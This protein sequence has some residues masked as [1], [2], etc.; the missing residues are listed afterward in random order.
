M[1]EAEEL[2]RAIAIPED[3]EPIAR[4]PYEGPKVFDQFHPIPR[5]EREEFAA[6]M[7]RA[8]KVGLGALIKKETPID[9]NDLQV[10]KGDLTAKVD[11]P[12]RVVRVFIGSAAEDAE[13]ERN[14][15]LLDV[16]PFLK[17]FCQRLGYEFQPVDLKFGRRDLTSLDDDHLMHNLAV[18][19][20]RKCL[21]VSAGPAFM[22]LLGNK[23]GPHTI[24]SAIEKTEFNRIFQRLGTS[25]AAD[26]WTDLQLLQEWFVLDQ[27]VR[28]QS[29]VLQPISTVLPGF[30]S[31]ESKATRLAV[32]KWWEVYG[33]IRRLLVEGSA[34]LNVEDRQKY[35]KG[36]IEEEI[37][38]A[39]ETDS[40]ESQRALVFTRDFEGLLE[41]APEHPEAAREYI[42]M[43]GRK[44]DVL[45]TERLAHLRERLA[46]A[47]ASTISWIDGA[48]FNPI[49]E[50]KHA[51]HIRAFCDE[52]CRAVANNA[53]LHH[54]AR[55]VEERSHLVQEVA[56]HNDI[57]AKKM[58]GFMGHE[59]LLEHLKHIV[60]GSVGDV[61]H[62]YII[63]GVSGSGKSSL[64]ASSIRLAQEQNPAVNTV[65]RA[66][67]STADSTDIRPLLR[68]LI[69]QIS[70]I[71]GA[72]SADE[73]STTDFDQL[74]DAFH[75]SLALAKE[76]SPLLVVLD[77]PEHLSDLNDGRDLAWFPQSIPAH[78]RLVVATRDTTGEGVG[79][80]DLFRSVVPSEEQYL[81]VPRLSDEAVEQLVQKLRQA[82][83]RS[84][85]QLQERVLLDACKRNGL[86]FYVQLASKVASSWRAFTPVPETK[87]APTVG[88]LM[89][90][91]FE[92]LEKTHGRVFVSRTLLYLAAS[93]P[94]GL[95]ETELLDILNEDGE[96]LDEI[97]KSYHFTSPIRRLPHAAWI[98]L[99][100]DLS[101]FLEERDLFGRTFHSRHRRFWETA[102]E[103]YLVDKQTVS[104]AHSTIADL[105]SARW[106]ST[107]FGHGPQGPLRRTVAATLFHLIE[108][109][110]SGDIISALSNAKS[111]DAAVRAGAI[112]D[113]LAVVDEAAG[114]WPVIF[115]P[116]KRMGKLLA[117]ER[118]ELVGKPEALAGRI[119]TLQETMMD[120]GYSY[121]G[122]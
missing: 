114:K 24:P 87:L 64:A 38:A 73:L 11:E 116:V 53:L 113:L 93:C 14:A 58:D 20:L 79:C 97:F 17:Q 75:A 88:E 57:A 5:E 2:G 90:N 27:N 48:G 81:A 91:V 109:E 31:G 106:Q 101:F 65:Y 74:I 62:P 15:L 85:T 40:V 54:E 118:E 25:N 100:A 51:D 95:T 55:T 68:S 8:D 80:F 86:P 99:K 56:A 92:R 96:V 61:S 77:G 23:F 18:A 50:A 122:L 47:F 7:E 82:E 67:G 36:W 83:R 1:E 44:T 10:L 89:D 115:K 107:E 4:S 120:N 43:I 112:D 21:E 70:T 59:E 45:A 26:R 102:E 3:A 105:L 9:E 117:A 71:Y 12:K 37:E 98:R 76:E 69:S 94:H 22:C 34:V 41:D 42:D 49:E 72:P 6:L 46:P 28:P 103:R 39:F 52:F 16:Y 108:A 121:F 66:I 104:K 19:E 60:E 29:Y 110:R 13:W 33:R 119:A 32:E 78:V 111:L 30:S 63:H 35:M 84:L